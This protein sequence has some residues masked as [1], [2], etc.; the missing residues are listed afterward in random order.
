[1]KQGWA[2]APRNWILVTKDTGVGDPKA[3]TGEKGDKFFQA[4]TDRI[5][6]FLVELAASSYASETDKKLTP[7]RTKMAKELQDSFLGLVAAVAKHRRVSQPAF[8]E[9]LARRSA[10]INVFARITGDAVTY[11][12]DSLAKN[13][14]K[15]SPEALHTVVDRFAASQVRVPE[16]AGLS[17]AARIREAGA[18]KLFDDLV[19]TV[20]SLA[21]GH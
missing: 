1:M 15:L 12:A 6:R 9:E 7:H 19:E 16:E 4:L 17:K 10:T 11:A 3:A 8:L 2:W 18:R 14:G 5:G 21:H 20:E 13:R